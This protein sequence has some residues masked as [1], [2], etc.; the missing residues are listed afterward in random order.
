MHPGLWVWWTVQGL[1]SLDFLALVG[2]LYSPEWS[3]GPAMKRGLFLRRRRSEH[4][5]C[6]TLPMKST[7][8][9]GRCPVSAAEWKP[10][11][12]VAVPVLS[13]MVPCRS[14]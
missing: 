9:P 5:V 14:L 11:M 10:P 6:V 7:F 2:A 4:K 13:S 8:V 12:R 1:C 3:G